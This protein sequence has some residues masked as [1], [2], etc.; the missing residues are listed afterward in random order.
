MAEPPAPIPDELPSALPDDP[1]RKRLPF[2]WILP[3]VVVVVAAFVVVQQKLAQGPR[4]DI[5]FLSADGIEA[6]KTKIRYKDVDIGDVT[7][8]HVSKDRKKVIV[9]ARIHRDASEYLVEDT[10]FWAVRP[11]FAGGNVSGLGTLVSGVYISVDV[12][13]SSTERRSFEGL[14]VPPIVTS[15]LPGREFILRADDIGSLSVGSTVFYRHMSAGQVIAYA[16]DPGGASVTIKVFIYKPYDSYVTPSTRFWQASGIDMSMSSEGVKLRTESLA[17]ILEGGVAFQALPSEKAAEPVPAD[18]VFMLY[19]DE[20]RALRQ[21]DTEVR[22][23]LMYFGG[24]LRGLSAGAPVDLRG[25]TIGEVK[26]LSV[27]Y[28]RSSGTLRFPVEVDIFPQRIRG[29]RRRGD[30]PLGTDETSETASRA[31][32]DSLVARGM[33]AELRTGSLLTGQKY[34]ALDFH[35]EVPA[36]HVG[37]DSHPAVFPTTAGALDEIQDSVGSIAKKLD[38]VPFDKI[39]ARLVTTMS[40]LDDTLK[41][42]DRMVRQ[43]D[44]TIAPQISATLQ[45]AQGAMKNAKDVLAQDAPLQSDLSATLLQLSRAAKSVSA[46]VDYLERHP[47]SLLRGKPEDAR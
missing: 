41:N 15:D 36:D 31:L 18:T 47:E 6:N 25:I 22:T 34:V 9:S 2:V 44:G 5:S 37:W 12:G 39:T 40:T 20:E 19:T 28:E 43:I 4:V 8:I 45:E 1:R 21:A 24:S 17:S 46:L 13:H 30:H 38:K 3:V 42:V 10:R 32:V 26:G 27:E 14:E 11:R 29:P 35:T 33:R 7:D 16:L 23:F